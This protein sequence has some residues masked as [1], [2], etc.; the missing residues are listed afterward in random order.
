MKFLDFARFLYYRLFSWLFHWRV[1]TPLRGISAV[2]PMLRRLPI[3]GVFDVT[4]YGISFRYRADSRDLIG[5]DI[6]WSGLEAIEPETLAFLVPRLDGQTLFVDAGANTGLFTII[7]G[8]KGALHIVSAEPVRQ[9]F[10]CLVANV[11][12]NGL[13]ERTTLL[14]K[15]LGNKD[16]EATLTVPRGDVFPTSSSLIVGGWRG[17]PGQEMAVPTV[18]LD[19]AL[20]EIAPE[21]MDRVSRIVAKIDVEGFELE[22]LEGF[23][24]YLESHPVEILFEANDAKFLRPVRDFLEARG[25]A[26]FQITLSGL[27]PVAGASF[28]GQQ[29]YRNFFATRAP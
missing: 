18:R 15:A 12:V 10:D 8:V 17:A 9:V 27:V 5:R 13:S 29:S 1:A 25:F 19:T 3:Y 21:V 20:D 24:H 26:V 16:G 23:T 22:V 6:F 4:G 2:F 7:A 14:A 11:A 28:G